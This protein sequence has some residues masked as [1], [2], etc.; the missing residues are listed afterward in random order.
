MGKELFEGRLLLKRFFKDYLIKI[1]DDGKE[2]RSFLPFRNKQRE[3]DSYSPKI[4]LFSGENGLGK[5]SALNICI[6]SAKE[7]ADEQKKSVTGIVIDWDSWYLKKGFVPLTVRELTDS[8]FDIF[9]E[10]RYG[11]SSYFSSYKNLSDKLKKISKLIE[12]LKSDEWPRESQDIPP[13]NEPEEFN[14]WLQKKL[15]KQD[16]ESFEKSE[17][18]LT[19]ILIQGLKDCSCDSVVILSVDNYDYL[20]PELDEWFRTAFLSQICND[21]TKIISIISGNNQLPRGFRNVFPEDLLY[22][23]NFSD[24]TLTRI[25]IA[26][27]ARKMSLTLSENQ[28]GEIEQYTAGIPIVVRDVFNYLKAGKNLNDII[29]NSLSEVWNIQV[30]SE[31]ILNRL[32]TLP[33]DPSIKDKVFHLSMLKR[34][35]PEVLQELWYVKSAELKKIL[36]DMSR[37]FAFIES[38]HVHILLRNCIKS[39]LIQEFSPG[40]ESSL[41]PFFDNYS[42]ICS[43]FFKEQLKKLNTSPVRSTEDQYHDEKYLDVAES[44]LFSLV[45]SSPQDALSFLLGLY[46]ELVYFNPEFASSLLWELDEFRNV[47]SASQLEVIDILNSGLITSDRSLFRKRI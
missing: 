47:M 37:K 18:Q 3:Q 20:S 12:E 39:Y 10:K 7:F 33:E 21:D 6:E 38:N 11:I 5:S 42:K 36:N 31:G 29:D 28:I 35:N 34:Y 15:K 16:L 22:I 45:W 1:F 4:I 32:L 25:E 17:S 43:R 44:Y 24:I 27:L 14:L 13:E 40:S 2:T 19:N 41:K 26:H 46:I 30:L 23:V 9:S 8:L